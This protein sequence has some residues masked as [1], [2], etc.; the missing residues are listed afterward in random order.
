MENH[1]MVY[2]EKPKA[3]NHSENVFRYLVVIGF[4]VV[5][6]VEAWLLIQVIVTLP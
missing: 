6:A 3:L 1:R 5:L 4:F 2:Q